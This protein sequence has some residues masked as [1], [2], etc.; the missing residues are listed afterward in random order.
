MFSVSTDWAVSASQTN[1]TATATKAAV[2]N[3]RHY[4]TSITISASAAPATAVQ[5]TMAGGGACICPL[6]IPAASFS[7]V[8]INFDPPLRGDINTAA[9]ISL[10]ALGASVTGTVVIR[11]YTKHE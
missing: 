2:A 1:A 9:N 6:E 4:I 11:G 3:A 10:P 5:A 7:P 8:S